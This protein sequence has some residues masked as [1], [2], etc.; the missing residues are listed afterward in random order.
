MERALAIGG[1]VGRGM[2]LQVRVVSNSISPGCHLTLSKK[3][4]LI[5]IRQTLVRPGFAIRTGLWLGVQSMARDRSS[6]AT[7]ENQG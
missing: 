1:G 4:K 5:R 6:L 3:T 7:W 2:L